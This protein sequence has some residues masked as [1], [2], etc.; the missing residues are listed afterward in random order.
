MQIYFGLRIGTSAY[1][2][3]WQNS[4]CFRIYEFM[5]VS[6]INLD[7]FIFNVSS[8]SSGLYT[9]STSSSAGILCSW[10]EGFDANI[11]FRTGLQRFL[12]FYMLSGCG[13]LYLFP[14]PVGGSFSDDG[15][16]RSSSEHS[17]MSLGGTFCYLYS[18]SLVLFLHYGTR[19]SSLRFLAT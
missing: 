7:G 3:Q 1:F 18:S 12:T 4:R 2:F 8:I 6:L 13:S 10:G 19:L 16:A 5:S 14:S 15:W 11:L 9:L 17:R